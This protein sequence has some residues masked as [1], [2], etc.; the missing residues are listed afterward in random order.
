MNRPGERGPRKEG[1]GEFK[2]GELESQMSDSFRS[3]GWTGAVERGN[4]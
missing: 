2:D 3:K 4:G 1:V